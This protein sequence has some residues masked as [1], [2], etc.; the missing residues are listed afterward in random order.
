MEDL[1]LGYPTFLMVVGAYGEDDP[2]LWQGMERLAK[3]A[4]LDRSVNGYEIAKRM[5]ASFKI[6]APP[7]HFTYLT[8]ELEDL[9]RRWEM[10]R[11]K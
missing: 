10:T 6:N 4:E 8:V 5:I 2:K 7:P 11:G 1:V 9:V 3:F